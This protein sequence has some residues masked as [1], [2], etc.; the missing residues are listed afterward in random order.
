MSTR[1]QGHLTLS[2]CLTTM[3]VFRG[4]GHA[5]LPAK[6]WRDRCDCTEVAGGIWQLDR[7]EG[8]TGSLHSSHQDIT[9]LHV[10]VCLHTE[11]MPC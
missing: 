5:G 8:P 9:G 1:M 6:A 10:Q 3:L 4:Q 7:G 11:I 2:H